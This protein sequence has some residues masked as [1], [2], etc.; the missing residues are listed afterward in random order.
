M[1]ID[2]HVHLL[3]DCTDIEKALR[4]E[5]IYYNPED[6]NKDLSSFFIKNI[7]IQEIKG[8]INQFVSNK[9][10]RE[11]IPEKDYL[12]MIYRLLADSKEID[13]LVLLA[14]DGSYH[15][16]LHSLQVRQT[17]LLITN[18][19]LFNKIN[20]MNDRLIKEGH[21]GKRFLLG[22]SVNPNR[23]DW[24]AELDYVIND[25]D[26]VLLKL[27]PSVHDVHL[28]DPAHIAFWNKLAGANLPL[29]C[30]VGP[31]LAFAEGLNNPELDNFRFLDYPLKHGVK[32]IACHCAAPFFPGHEDKVISFCNYLNEK[33]ANGVKLW[34]DTSA[35]MSTYRVFYIRRFV[36]DYNPAYLIHGSDMP[37]PVNAMNHMPYITYDVTMPEFIDFMNEKN[38]FDKEILIK[39]AHGF[40][41]SILSNAVNVLRLPKNLPIP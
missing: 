12:E 26:A 11:G 32:V 13:A 28:D 8:F 31:E 37:V 35:L 36:K 15:H 41:D 39:R 7:V 38:P 5:A 21:K 3:G 19:F 34:A 20:E 6:N 16:R 29:L 33:N 27:I 22:A 4:H 9:I 30:H 1:K 24:D 2:V 40:R 25:T 10:A 17:D 14:M 23:A 18:K